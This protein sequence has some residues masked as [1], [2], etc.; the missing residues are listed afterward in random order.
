MQGT[1]R[2]TLE[3]FFTVVV[4][5]RYN[6]KDMQIKWPDDIYY[7]ISGMREYSQSFDFMEKLRNRLPLSENCARETA[8]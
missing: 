7:C 8:A 6:L 4:A 2:Y 5:V 1:L 3:D